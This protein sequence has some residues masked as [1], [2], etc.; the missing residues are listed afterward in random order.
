[1]PR[2]NRVAPDGS[3]HAVAARG[4]WMGNRGC[5]HDE[6]GELTG[7]RWT[8]KAWICCRLDFKNRK[9]E[10]TPPGRYTSLFFLDEATALAA[11][12]RPCGECRR[13]A[14][15][16]FIR[17]AGMND[18]PIAVLDDSLHA[19]RIASDRRKSRIDELPDGAIISLDDAFWLLRRGALHRWT[20]FGYT[21]RRAI[22][23][24]TSV[25]VITPT[26][27]LTALCAGY[28][29]LIIPSGSDPGV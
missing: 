19:I 4:A 13:E 10:P 9:R 1:V 27:C 26:P 15:L 3:L 22:D 29:V 12:H 5:L 24:T 6:R 28:D 18:H 17:A 2:R 21:E 8:T 16:A 7:R 25:R 23:A 14:F 11:G 20:P